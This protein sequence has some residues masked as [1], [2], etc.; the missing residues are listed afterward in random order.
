[1]DS[2]F[3]FGIEV[4]ASCPI[5]RGGRA[6]GRR[7]SPVR[8]AGSQTESEDKAGWVGIV[9]VLI[10]LLL[11]MSGCVWIRTVYPPH[12]KA[13]RIRK[14]VKADIWVTDKNGKELPSRIVLKEGGF[15]VP[16]LPKEGK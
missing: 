16:Y 9:G 6:H 7:R 8:R 1:M 2:A 11:F 15:Y 10:L 5:K 3:D 12:G 4:T 14:D 13:V